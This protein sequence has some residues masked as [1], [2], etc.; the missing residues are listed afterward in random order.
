MMDP[1]YGLVLSCYLFDCRVKAVLH[2]FLGR[3][4]LCNCRVGLLAAYAGS[5]RGQDLLRGKKVLELG[6]G[7]GLPGLVA[8]RYA[9][10]VILTDGSD[11]VVELLK[12]NVRDH[13]FYED[14]NQDEHGSNR[15]IC[16]NIVRE[17]RCVEAR[18]LLWGDGIEIKTILERC[19]GYVDV[20]FAA[21]VVQWPAVVQP[22]L[23]S[24]KALLWGSN[25]PIFVLGIVQRAQSTTRLFFHLA[26]ELGF[27]WKRIDIDKY[28]SGG[29]FPEACR[30]FGGLAPEIYEIIL[31]DRSSAPALFSSPLAD[32]STMAVGKAYEHTFSLPC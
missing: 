22:L 32:K 15:E 8:S 11:T 10:L 30:E 24:V 28:H 14:F 18:R 7:C 19:E 13:C 6:A 27:A 2:E 16:N 23:H 12:R 3:I 21:D 9:R 20:V 31:T 1:R 29:R 26:E 25:K 4:L 17:K 5:Q